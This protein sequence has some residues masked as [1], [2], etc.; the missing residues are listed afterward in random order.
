MTAANLAG[1]NSLYKAIQSANYQKIISTFNFQEDEEKFSKE[2]GL[3][4][5]DFKTKMYHQKEKKTNEIED[6]KFKIHF[7]FVLKS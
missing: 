4:V 7:F 2:F 5:S 6:L 3:L 1:I